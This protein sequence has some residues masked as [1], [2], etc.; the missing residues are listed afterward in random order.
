MGRRAG[1]A[2]PTPPAPM[3]P[4][5][6]RPCGALSSSTPCAPIRCMTKPG[7]CA[8]PAI[9]RGRGCLAAACGTFGL[10]SIATAQTLREWQR[11]PQGSLVA[12]GQARRQPIV[13]NPARTHRG[14]GRRIQ[15]REN[16]A[17]R[18]FPTRTVII[19]SRPRP[20]H[21]RWM[22]TSR[23]STSDPEE[24]DAAGRAP[25]PLHAHRAL[26]RP[27]PRALLAEGRPGRRA[28]QGVGGHPAEGNEDLVG[29]SRARRASCA[30]SSRRR[31]AGRGGCSATMARRA[32]E[33]ERR[34]PD[35]TTTH[36]CQSR[37]RC[38]CVCCR[39]E[40]ATAMRSALS[41]ARWAMR[42]RA[43]PRSLRSRAY[44]STCR[45][46][47]SPTTRRGRA[48]STSAGERPTCATSPRPCSGR[49]RHGRKRLHG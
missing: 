48:S 27:G 23:R 4:R 1:V 14:I 35:S 22:G 33:C 9:R 43:R 29:S 10:A 16:L 6:Q 20:A 2:K 41:C 12:L 17:A 13:R 31:N 26:G 28:G 21:R 40:Q 32:T 11:N 24:V 7:P 34:P 18:G 44:R 36:R 3:R 46:R 5:P 37:V 39:S 45:A 8:A 15:Q 30:T 47:C 19:E 42:R 49:M 25:V 38:R